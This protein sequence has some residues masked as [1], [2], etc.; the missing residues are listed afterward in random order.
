MLSAEA[1]L[2]GSGLTFAVEI[3]ERL[4][5]ANGLFLFPAAVPPG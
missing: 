2:A 4:L 5:A 1:L 3:P